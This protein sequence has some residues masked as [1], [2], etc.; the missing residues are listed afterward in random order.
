M[1]LSKYF[2]KWISTKPVSD[3]FG[4][5]RGAPIDRYYIGKFLQKNKHLIYGD[6]LEVADSAYTKKFGSDRVKKSLVFS[7]LAADGVDFV[8]D[9]ESG[10]GIAKD[11]ADCFIMTQT[12]PFI[13]DL[14]S[15]VKNSIK[16]L[17]PGGHLLITASGITQISRYDYDRWGQFWCFTEMSLKMLFDHPEVEEVIVESYGNVKAST[18]FLYGLATHEL[19]KAELDYSDKNYQMLITAIVKKRNS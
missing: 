15:A 8:G 3:Q 14:K 19:S 7:Y 10:D 6:V 17:R 9:L 1:N 13:F 5:D 18:A 2:L 16:M 12:L 11:I 4:F